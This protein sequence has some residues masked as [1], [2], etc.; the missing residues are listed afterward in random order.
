VLDST[1]SID[2]SSLDG[3]LAGI[4][5]DTF[6]FKKRKLVP[7][8]FGNQGAIDLEETDSEDE[9]ESFVGDVSMGSNSDNG[10]EERTESD[11]LAE[12]EGGL[13][14]G[15]EV[16]MAGTY[17]IADDTMERAIAGSQL[18][19]T[20]QRL[21]QPQGSPAK[22]QLDLSGNWTEQLQRTISPR[23]QDRQALRELQGN[24]FSERNE[25]DSPK[26]KAATDDRERG[27][28]TSID[29]MNSLFRQPTGSGQ[30]RDKKLDRKTKG[31]EV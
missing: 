20:F 12:S 3:S 21:K 11:G 7:G 6:E 15:D 8:A 28:V 10:G 26:A 5:D 31:F 25:M 27:F 19:P 24:I 30:S 9:Q 1:I 14:E 13:Y 4:E 2:D 22:A 18:K 23:K 17:P 29:L 16:E